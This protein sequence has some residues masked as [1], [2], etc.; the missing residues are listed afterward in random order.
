MKNRDQLYREALRAWGPEL[1]SLMLAEEIGELLQAW[2]KYRRGEGLALDVVEEIAD[3][4]IML[5]QLEIMIA[6][7]A[8]GDV[9]GVR[10]GSTMAMERKIARLGELLERL[11]AVEQ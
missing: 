2:S 5:E 11:D 7:D 4:R 8:A 1:Q 9:A 3:V 6:E 10:A